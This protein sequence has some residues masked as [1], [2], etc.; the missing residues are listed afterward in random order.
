[1]WESCYSLCCRL[2]QGLLCLGL[3][4]QYEQPKLWRCRE[5]LLADSFACLVDWFCATGWMDERGR[6]CNSSYIRTREIRN[7]SGWK[8]DKWRA[9]NEDVRYWALGHVNV[10]RI[11][12]GWVGV[13]SD[14][15]VERRAGRH[16]ICMDSLQ[17]LFVHLL[18]HFR[19][20][21]DVLL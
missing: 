17:R 11:E 19:T 4:M 5:L 6:S 16:W 14:T 7:M 21:Y 12:N 1:M 20:V 18:L 10:A 3:N 2:M 9:T 13:N 8:V 15:I